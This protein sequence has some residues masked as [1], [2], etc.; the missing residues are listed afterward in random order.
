MKPDQQNSVESESNEPTEIQNDSTVPRSTANTPSDSTPATN[1]FT[2]PSS[3]KL[4]PALPEI[5]GYIVHERLG[6]GGFGDVYK[7]HSIE[8]DGP[9]AIKVLKAK[10]RHSERAVARFDQEVR[11]AAQ[12]RHGNVVQVLTRGLV[13]SGTSAGCHFLVTEY[14]PGG[15]FGVWLKQFK[16]GDAGNL[17][18]AVE[19]LVDVCTA[20]E[21]VHGAG[22]VHRDLKPEN[23]LLDA[24]GN[25]KLADFGLAAFVE[26]EDDR[27]TMSDEVL[28][29]WAYMSPE[30]IR[31]AR[32]CT[33]L[34]D[35]YAI[36]VM[37]Y[38][39]LCDLRPWQE[40][41]NDPHE[42]ERILSNLQSLPISPSRKS[43]H[44]DRKLQSICLRCLEPK[45][46][47]RYAS[48]ADL[49]ADLVRWLNN[50]PISSDKQ[51][52]RLWHKWLVRPV[53]RYPIRTVGSLVAMLVFLAI[54]FG[55]AY[56]LMYVRPTQAYFRN[57][58]ERHGVLHGIHPLSIEAVKQRPSSYRITRQ[59]WYGKITQVDILN[60]YL[61]PTQKVGVPISFNELT[62]IEFESG[63]LDTSLYSEATFKYEYR[64]NGK[65]NRVSAYSWN[66][67]NLWVKNYDS[68]TQARYQ[69]LVAQP[70]SRP[71]TQ[72]VRKVL[73]RTGSSFGRL[74]D[75]STAAKATNVYYEYDEQGLATYAGFF[76][77]KGQPQ[78]SAI[79]A[80]GYRDEHDSVGRITKRTWLDADRKPMANIMGVVSTRLNFRHDEIEVTNLNQQGQLVR[81]TRETARRVVKL[82]LNGRPVE[83]KEFDAD[84]SPTHD[85]QGVHCTKLAYDES[86]NLVKHSLFDTR[87][88][89]VADDD[90]AF[91]AIARYDN[92]GRQ[93]FADVFF[94]ATRNQFPERSRWK[95]DYQYQPDG[96]VLFE[97]G[98]YDLKERIRAKVGGNVN[99]TG[100]QISIAF[101]DSNDIPL[102]ID[103][104]HR[105][106]TSYDRMGNETGARYF[107]VQGE[108]VLD[109]DHTHGYDAI[110]DASGRMLTR[111]YVGLNGQPAT[112]DSGV[113]ETRFAYNA[114]GENISQRYFDTQGNP[115]AHTNGEYGFDAEYDE[116]GN[117]VATNYVDE[118]GKPVVT[119]LGYCRE[120]YKHD[121][122]GNTI[123]TRYY[124][125]KNEPATHSDGEHGFYAT[126]NERGYRISESYF[127]FSDAPILLDEGYHRVEFKHDD[128]G[129]VIS[130]RYFDVDGEPANGEDGFH[131]YEVRFDM[132]RRQVKGWYLNAEEETVP[133]LGGAYRL[134]WEYN[135]FGAM[136]GLRCFDANERPMLNDQGIHHIQVK[137][138]DYR[139]PLEKRAFGVNNEP[140]L[141]WEGYHCEKK[142][143]DANSNAIEGRYLGIDNQPIE[144]DD[145]FMWRATFDEHG[146]QLTWAAFDADETP[147]NNEMGYHHR[148]VDPSSDETNFFDRE[149]TQLTDTAALVREV[150]TDTEA[151]R[152]GLQVGDIIHSYGGVEGGQQIIIAAIGRF[153]ESGQSQPVRVQRDGEMI[154]L[155]AQPGTLG[156][157]LESYY[158]K[159]SV[160]Q[161]E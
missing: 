106:V 15:D 137:V 29:T 113:H 61:K 76:D 110:S 141:A 77:G 6:G 52:I 60:G 160:I 116:H 86:G 26:S 39:I 59:G 90:G 46:E 83:I 9:V 1:D 3:L 94:E 11:A 82:D 12:N 63:G 34:S 159:Q 55:G 54:A 85:W 71:Q 84:N 161:Q 133:A 145:H 35:Q 91:E 80:F 109:E 65:V 126:Y 53:T 79:G 136:I 125:T 114:V 150:F 7:A 157:R 40:G 97:G 100:D 21:S 104:V 56:W 22:V 10:F 69:R 57:V 64:E 51:F 4:T 108:P 87:M 98:V 119:S 32:N 49:K 16:H 158:S 127:D 146:N 93:I 33:P 8:L 151:E 14:L 68:L 123:E 144:V 101:F 111:A 37:L 66:G 103:S 149:G 24:D 28:G 156:V 139:N 147:V 140:V 112:N 105:T 92:S 25:P 128:D 31:G 43:N 130:K 44:V 36:G 72:D 19:K 132:L 50:E 134:Q 138:D 89:P 73:G 75:L 81:G 96:S 70:Q 120:E 27:L 118:Q 13:Q 2:P 115:A 42:R 5:E 30:Q 17:T 47:L 99:R 74:I 122:F 18:E 102:L 41:P 155:D 58:V 121:E 20:L 142:K 95:L 88:L 131:G 148:E 45:P 143:F 154:T 78:P 107:G 48:I 117:Q 62:G 67:E 135:R 38:K 129:N 152:I 23:I 124:D 153:K